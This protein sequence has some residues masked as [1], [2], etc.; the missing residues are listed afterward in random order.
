MAPMGAEYIDIILDETPLRAAMWNYSVN[1]LIL[2][3]MLSAMIAAL[4][5]RSAERPRSQ[6]RAPPDR[7]I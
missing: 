3:L 1:I 2:S 5:V 4:A 6:T 7:Q